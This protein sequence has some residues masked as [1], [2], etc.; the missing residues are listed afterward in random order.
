MLTRPPYVSGIDERFFNRDLS[1]LAFN[2]RVLSLARE[3]AI[4]LLE[5]AKFCAIFS[6]NLDEFFQVRVAGLKHQIDDGVLLHGVDGRSP[7]QVLAEVSA[8]VRRLVSEQEELLTNGILP[9]LVE[10]G[11][12]LT[13]WRD[14]DEPTRERLT[15]EFRQRIFPVLTP[16]VVDPAHPFPYISGLALSIGAT[17]VDPSTGDEKFTRVKVPPLLPRLVEADAAGTFVTVEDIIIAHLGELYEGMD[18]RDPFVFR[19]TRDADIEVDDEDADDLREA[20][21]E[22]LRR[23]RF[24]R[25][26][27]LETVAGVPAEVVTLLLDEL[28]LEA[29]DHFESRLPLDLTCLQRIAGL[30]RRDLRDEPWPSVTAGRVLAARE[31]DEPIFNLIR[32]R[33]LVVHHPYE[34]FQT[35]TEAFIEEAARDPRVQSIKMT[36][37]RTSPDSAI[38]RNLITA[39]ERGVQVVVLVELKA[40]FDEALNLNWARQLERAGVHVMYGIVGLKTHAKVAMVVRD[41]PD[42]LRRYVHFGTGNY[43]AKTAAVYE[44]IGIFTCNPELADDTTRLFNH[45]TGFS[46]TNWYR[47]LLVAPHFLRR[48]MVDLI[49]RECDFG[50]NGLIRIK[51]NSIA[52]A[53]VI[54]E[55]YEASRAGVRIEIIVRGICMLRPGVPGL[56]ENITVRSILGR[57]LEHSRIYHFANAG[58]PDRPAWYIGSADLMTRN[59]DRRVE[60]LTPVLLDRHR[61]WLE[62]ALGYLN[63]DDTPHFTLEA[64]GSWSRRGRVDF[65]D[66]AQERMYRWAKDQ[67][68]R[69]TNERVDPSGSG[70]VV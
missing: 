53:D 33:D 27:R 57:Y 18:V 51:V 63:D 32:R 38:M 67:Q 64:D 6:S 14:L 69:R 42:G 13:A 34:S 66:D 25:A 26:V 60:V 52:D 1:W 56:S 5:R 15:K 68:E 46:R 17:V 41:E 40:R 28:E 24:G 2:E 4:P 7:A 9:A 47:H 37:Y 45:L 70:S 48:E 55:L 62:Q 65:V 35:S 59:L 50:D 16:L 58:G 10:N 36:L 11:I 29:A 20:I 3:T 22:E 39:A 8:T 23:R 44:D 43:N 31:N 61:A 30:P 19:V 12:R 49:H 21:E 54:A